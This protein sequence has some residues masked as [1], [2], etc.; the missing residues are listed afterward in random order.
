M[1]VIRLKLVV[2]REHA[3]AAKLT[4]AAKHPAPRVSLHVY[5]GA[6][7]ESAVGC[8]W[9]AVGFQR[10]KNVCV[11]VKTSARDAT[12]CYL[13]CKEKRTKIPATLRWKLHLFTTENEEKIQKMSAEKKV[14]NTSVVDGTQAARAQ[15]RSRCCIP[16]RGE[17]C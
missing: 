2:R 5:R 16:G 7:G 17:R 12:I 14:Q 13:C 3:A 15:G 4:V 8:V 1:R 6:E 10:C 11:G 9:A